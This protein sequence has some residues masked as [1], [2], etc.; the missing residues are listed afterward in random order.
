MALALNKLI[1]AGSNATT[2]T[3]GAYFQT[4]TISPTTANTTVVPA[5]AYIIPATANV[6]YSANNGTTF[7]QILAVNTASPFLV[8]DGVNVICNIGTN[9]NVTLVTVNGGEAVVGTY[10]NK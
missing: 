5:G 8:S 9:A 7:V 3:A 4:V 6:S 1:L 2:N 10:N